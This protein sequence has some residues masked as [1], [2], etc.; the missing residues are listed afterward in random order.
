MIYIVY[1][2][3]YTFPVYTYCMFS[4]N[5]NKNQDEV[6]NQYYY[7]RCTN[8]HG[9]VLLYTCIDHRVHVTV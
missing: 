8:L 3:M 1:I 2:Y 9:V 6:L 4:I 5:E 7:V